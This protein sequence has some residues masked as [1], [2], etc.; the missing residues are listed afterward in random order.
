M[1]SVLDRISAVLEEPGGKYHLL[2][3]ISVVLLV[4]SFM[5]ASLYVLITSAA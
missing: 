1:K 5:G 3:T 4:L 2:T